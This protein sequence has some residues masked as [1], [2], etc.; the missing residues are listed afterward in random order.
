MCLPLSLFSG[1]RISPFDPLAVDCDDGGLIRP[2]VQHFGPQ[3]DISSHKLPTKVGVNDN[4]TR[5]MNPTVGWSRLLC[6][7]TTIGQSF[8]CD[9]GFLLTRL[10][11]H[12]QLYFLTFFYSHTS[13]HTFI[14]PTRSLSI[15]GF[16]YLLKHRLQVKLSSLYS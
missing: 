9:P 4:G 3:K 10:R 15:F 14:I 13:G 8:I 16:T 2:S 7:V 1:P 11:S 5:R 12:G 6:F